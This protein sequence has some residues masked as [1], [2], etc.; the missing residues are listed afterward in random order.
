MIKVYFHYKIKS[1]YRVNSKNVLKKQSYINIKSILKVLK[2]LNIISE[3]IIARNFMI[4][5]LL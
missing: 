4:S 3:V 5:L 2:K 1:I